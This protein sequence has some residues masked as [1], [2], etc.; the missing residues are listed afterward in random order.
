MF[1]AHMNLSNK[2]LIWKCA[3]S[4][5][6]KTLYFLPTDSIQTHKNTQPHIGAGLI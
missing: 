1:V 4:M 3:D 5:I 6:L 2:E